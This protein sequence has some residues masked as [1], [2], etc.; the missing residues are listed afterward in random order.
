MN[1]V[2]YIAYSCWGWDSIPWDGDQPPPPFDAPVKLW[3]VYADGRIEYYG[4]GSFLSNASYSL[5]PVTTGLMYGYNGSIPLRSGPGNI[6]PFEGQPAC[7]V[8]EDWEETGELNEWGYPNYAQL[9]RLYPTESDMYAQTNLLCTIRD[10]P[11]KSEIS[12]VGGE[13]QSARI[14]MAL[15]AGGASEFWTDFV[16]SQEVVQ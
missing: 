9:Y 15:P 11:A 4:L 6:G 8:A 12:C 1:P 13:Y 3:W 5:D 10:L 14:L 16:G 7:Y 2:A